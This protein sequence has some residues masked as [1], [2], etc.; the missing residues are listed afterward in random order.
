MSTQTSKSVGHGKNIISLVVLLLT[1]VGLVIW[2]L[3]LW[4]ILPS[5]WGSLFQVILATL[6]IL[7]A[8]LQWRSQVESSTQVLVRRSG[9]DLGVDRYRGALVVKIG[10]Q[11]SGVDVVLY[12]GFGGSS[13][14]PYAASIIAQQRVG[15]VEMCAGLFPSLEPGNYTIASSCRSHTA[16]VTIYAG[17]ITEFDWR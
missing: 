16:R 14:E 6:G 1:L 15:E 10:L 12:R 17:Q 8:L 4:N 3:S 13:S 5:L 7:L 9:V 2:G 11:W